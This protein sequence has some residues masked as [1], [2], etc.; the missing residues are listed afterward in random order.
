METV[1]LT[2]YMPASKKT[3]FPAVA[4]L[5]RTGLMTAVSSVIL[6]P[7]APLLQRP[8]NF[9]TACLHIVA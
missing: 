9:E 6:S 2:L 4:A 3:T 1:E 5:E 7:L 8:T